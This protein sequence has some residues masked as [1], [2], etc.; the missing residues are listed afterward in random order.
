MPLRYVLR[1]WVALPVALLQAADEMVRGG[2]VRNR[3]ELMTNAMRRELG[4]LE[5]ARIDAE[6]QGVAGDGEYKQK[7][8]QILAEFAEADREA[9]EAVEPAARDTAKP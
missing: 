7:A 8:R 2:R 4:L 5:R 3:N 9:M 6:F 1:V